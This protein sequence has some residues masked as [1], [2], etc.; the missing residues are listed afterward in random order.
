[1]LSEA[2]ARSG[3]APASW[4]ARAALDV[5]R[6]DIVP[7]SRAEQ[8]VFLELRRPHNELGRITNSLNMMAHELTASGRKPDGQLVL[9]LRKVDELALEV[10]EM[11]F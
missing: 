7:Q 5:A 11:L 9:V 4:A 6:E 2:A 3:L 1:M 8:D 10:S